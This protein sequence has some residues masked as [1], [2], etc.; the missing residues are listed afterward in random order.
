[1]LSV[2][3]WVAFL[4]AHEVRHAEQIREDHSR[5]RMVGST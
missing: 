1:V 4:G 2:Y 5:S 3:Q